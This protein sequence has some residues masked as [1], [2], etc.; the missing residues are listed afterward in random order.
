MN[1]PRPIR[2]G[3]PGRAGLAPKIM[4][5]TQKTQNRTIAMN[6]HWSAKHRLGATM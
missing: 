1:R 3:R 6:R 2:P 5:P 4:N